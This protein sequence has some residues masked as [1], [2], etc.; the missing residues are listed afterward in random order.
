MEIMF[1]DSLMKLHHGKHISQHEYIEKMR[2]LVGDRFFV[3]NYEMFLN[4]H[5]GTKTTQMEIKHYH[6]RGELW[7]WA[8]ETLLTMMNIIDPDAIPINKPEIFEMWR[9]ILFNE[10]HDILP[11]SSIS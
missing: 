1:A 11:G 4:M 5:H 7:A 10:F 8:A 9:L 6:R 3:W 2:Q